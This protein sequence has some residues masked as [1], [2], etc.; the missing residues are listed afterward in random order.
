MAADACQCARS[1][2]NITFGKDGEE[3]SQSKSETDNG[4]VRKGEKSRLSAIR[5]PTSSVREYQFFPV[6]E[7]TPLFPKTEAILPRLQS[8]GVLQNPSDSQRSQIT[9]DIKADDLAVVRHIQSQSKKLAPTQEEEEDLLDTR[10]ATNVDDE[11]PRR[12][13]LSDAEIQSVRQSM[14]HLGVKSNQDLVNSA[15]SD[16]AMPHERDGHGEVPLFPHEAL[17]PTNPQ[18][19]YTPHSYTKMTPKLFPQALS[20]I[21][22]ISML[23]D[24]ILAAFPTGDDGLL[25]HKVAVTNS[26]EKLEDDLMKEWTDGE[27]LVSDEEEEE[28]EQLNAIVHS[29][30]FKHEVPLDYQQIRRQSIHRFSPPTGECPDSYFDISTATIARDSF[31]H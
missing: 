9:Q 20:R 10:E 1:S 27:D 30:T 12:R 22:T 5:V 14:T 8:E 2:V 26:K 4:R 17:T 13:Q 3:R 7:N 21:P 25:N 23:N 31:G 24:P 6:P 16:Q 11:T 28:E 15:E 29:P 19:T 18:S